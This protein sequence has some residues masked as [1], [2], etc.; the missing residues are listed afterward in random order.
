M[1]SETRFLRMPAQG[2]NPGTLPNKRST[3]KGRNLAAAL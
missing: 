3:L 1:S 2:F